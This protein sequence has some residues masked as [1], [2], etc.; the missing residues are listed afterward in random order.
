VIVAVLAGE[1]VADAAAHALWLVND[2]NVS[3]AQMTR[4]TIVEIFIVPMGHVRKECAF[5]LFLRLTI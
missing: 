2:V 1:S 5:W 4:K 3:I